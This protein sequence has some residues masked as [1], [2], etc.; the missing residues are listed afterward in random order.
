MDFGSV[1]EAYDRIRPTY[2]TDLV[3]A[4]AAAA[5]LGPGSRVLEIAPG[6]GQLSVPL[7]GLDV[8]LTAVELDPRMAAVAGR[9]LAPFPRARVEVSRFEQWTPSTARTQPFDLVVCATAFHWLDPAVRL[10]RCL[11][12]LRPG[13]VLAVI[14]GVLLADVDAD[15]FGARLQECITRWASGTPGHPQ[16]EHEIPIGAFDLGADPRAEVLPAQRFLWAREYTPDGLADL[17]ATFS[18]VLALDGGQRDELLACIRAAVAA[19]PGGT[20]LRRH[21]ADLQLA[22]RV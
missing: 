11:D 20:V 19:Q 8:D 2:P 9:R 18:T 3:A 16:E 15:R 6:T 21:L 14:G 5:R 10:A 1:A 17:V 13:G 4:L 7:A 12:V 22:R